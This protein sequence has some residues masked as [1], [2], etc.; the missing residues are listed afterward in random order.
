[1]NV[2]EWADE[3]DESSDSEMM[4]KIKEEG[5]RMLI[6][7]V[8]LNQK[9]NHRK[10]CKGRRSIFKNCEDVDLIMRESTGI[11]VARR[12]LRMPIVFFNHQML[13]CCVQISVSRRRLRLSIIFTPS[14]NRPKFEYGQS[15]F[16]MGI[17]KIS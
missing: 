9:G 13:I 10:N 15:N 6:S 8:V 7:V 2:I 11:D 3:E 17:G 12:V 14:S 16:L 1:L 4:S 5:R